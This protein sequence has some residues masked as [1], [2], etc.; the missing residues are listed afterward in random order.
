MGMTPKAILGVRHGRLP[1]AGPVVPR[2]LFLAALCTL[3]FSPTGTAADY[4]LAIVPQL[5]PAITHRNWAPVTERLA[6]ETGNRLQLRVYRTFEEFEAELS[7]GLPDLVYMNPYHQLRARQSHGY[8]PLI[9][10]SSQ[11]LSGVLV[12]HRDSPV[13]S[14]RELDGQTI[15]FPDANA[16]AA[17]LYMRALLQE[18]ERVRFLPQYLT[19]H[20]NVYR[21]VIAG[22]VAAGGGVNTT[23]AR[24]RP[25][26]RATLRVLYE[27]PG[28][29]P[30]P[31]SAHP[32][33]SREQRE[34]LIRAML[35]MAGDESGR[36]LL[37]AI[38][39]AK[40][41]RAD[42]VR[43]YAPLENLKLHKY[44]V[45]TKLPIR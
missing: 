31:L 35:D 16:F 1:A 19:T 5:S 41:I 22:D 2:L 24:E 26:T 25:E 43:D 28:T 33:L 20:G 27:T 3:L 40:P 38:Q 44:A 29:P 21:H 9:R 39:I 23:L 14:V 12:V 4:T 17:S 30:H 7:N 13:K 15:G 42:F 10:D 11:L 45:K 18:K 34:R 36:M 8:I 32:R 6:R 37:R